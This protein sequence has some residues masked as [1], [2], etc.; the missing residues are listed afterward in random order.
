[1]NSSLSFE[2]QLTYDPAFRKQLAKDSHL[3]YF[4]LYHSGYIRYETA[5]FQKEIFRLTEQEEV[6]VSVICAFRGSAKSTIVGLSYP[7]WAIIGRQQKKFVLL[8]SQ[9]Q[10]QARLNL[11]NIKQEIE[12]NELLSRDLLPIQEEIDEWGA[13]S[14][15]IPRFNARISIASTEQSIRGIR[16]GA[17][18]PDLIICD[19]VED[20][21]STK[22]KEGRD[23]TYAWFTSE[24]LPIGDVG[25]KIMVIG[26]LLHEDSLVM[27]L[28]ENIQDGDLDGLYREYPLLDSQ[29][30]TIWPTKFK[31]PLDIEKL[32][33]SVASESAWHREYLL[34]IISTSERIVHPEWI[35][36][37]R[38]LPKDKNNHRFSATGIDLAISKE[39]TAD[40]TAMVSAHVYSYDE[41][42]RIYILPNPINH[43]LNFP[44]TIEMA[45][46]LSKAVG[47]G[48][49]TNIIIEEVGYQKALIDDLQKQG[50][51]AEGIKA[52]GQ[53]KSARLSLTTHL[54]QS[55]QIVFPEKGCETLIQQLTGFGK[56]KH[57][58][59]ADAFAYLILWIIE[60]NTSEPQVIIANMNPIFSMNMFGEHSKRITLDTIF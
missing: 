17:H 30:K 36:Y 49:S 12:S 13:T 59:L 57:D 20:L 15:V 14:I 43:R 9:T 52:H 27:R 60:N 51:P 45:K 48:H 33:K 53:D 46:Q 6:K 35:H 22:T 8:V 3:W 31:T 58:D 32:K 47:D 2:D 34:H 50:Y 18:R 7:L 5:E 42:M 19:D 38:E 25:T 23:K 4:H 11:K 55:G 41:E 56:E 54:L 29:G 40:Y 21:M 37:Y 28:K 24:V 16:H 26:N 1:M 39:K 10:Y 44:E